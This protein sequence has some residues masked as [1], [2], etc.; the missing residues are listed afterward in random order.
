MTPHAQAVAEMKAF[1]DDYIATFNRGDY[2]QVPKFFTYPWLTSSRAGVIGV[3]PDEATQLKMWT[4]LGTAL[5]ARGWVRSAIERIDVYPTG[6]DTGM[7]D[8]DYAR[9]RA[10]DSILERSRAYYILRRFDSVWK[11]TTSIEPPPR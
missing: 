2:T 4:Q 5:R 11:I 6:G 1:Y 9:Y 7:L 10:D 3:I 8:V